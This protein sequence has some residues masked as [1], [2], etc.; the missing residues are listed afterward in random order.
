MG[1]LAVAA[2]IFAQ[3]SVAATGT[4]ADETAL[5]AQGSLVLAGAA[6]SLWFAGALRTYLGGHRRLGRDGAVWSGHFT[7]DRTNNSYHRDGGQ[8]RRET[9]MNLPTVDTSTAQRVADAA[10]RRRL[11]RSLLILGVAVTAATILLVSAV[12]TDTQDVTDNTFTT[13]EV[14]ISVSP[15]TAAIGMTG[16]VPGDQVTAP[17][18][19]TN[20][21]TV[22]LRYAVT[23]TTTE[24][25]LAA[26]LDLTV[27]VGVTTCTNAGF[28]IDG[29]DVYPTGILGS[30]AGTP[31]F[32]NPAQGAHTGD[33]VLAAAA[34][35]VLCFNVLLPAT[36]TAGAGL[37]TTATFTFDAE[38][39]TNNP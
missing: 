19:V 2:I 4:T 14:D 30:V 29:T 33:R 12:F 7:A 16:M 18:T 15:A 38:Q 26:E 24:D 34:N 31:I 32:G 35:E 8:G 11:L 23:S 27:K 22:E 13:G 10:D 6:V 17:L 39:T 1:F 20:A 3:A 21:G 28:V 37:T 25:V 5:V 36:A 9:I